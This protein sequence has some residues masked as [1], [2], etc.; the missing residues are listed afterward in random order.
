M[1][2]PPAKAQRKLG[3]EGKTSL[4]LMLLTFILNNAI[5]GLIVKQISQAL[6]LTQAEA[7]SV[8]GSG[9]CQPLYQPRSLALWLALCKSSCVCEGREGRGS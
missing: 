8:P 2:S 4:G 6:E 5:S 9:L 3:S 7:S 1:S